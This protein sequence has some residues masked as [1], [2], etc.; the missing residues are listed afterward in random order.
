MV[1]GANCQLPRCQSGGLTA[2]RW[3]DASWWRRTRPVRL[4]GGWWLTL[5]CSE[6]RVL[7]AGCGWLLVAGSFWEKSTAGWWL[8]SRANRLEV[9]HLLEP[10]VAGSPNGASVGGSVFIQARA[11][12][13]CSTEWL[14]GEWRAQQPELGIGHRHRLLD[15]SNDRR[16]QLPK[17]LS[18]SGVI[19]SVSVA[20]AGR[21][22]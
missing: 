22:G 8:I 21:R 18:L 14:C 9:D 5:V 17:C 10:D 13:T 7:L 2:M 16:P 12:T 4:A 3:E 6:R 11:R 15:T 19:G 1:L 20:S